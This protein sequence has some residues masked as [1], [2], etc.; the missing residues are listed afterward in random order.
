LLG[1]LISGLL[2]FPTM[3]H[4]LCLSVM[5]T[6][7]SALSCSPEFLRCFSEAGDISCRQGPAWQGAGTEPEEAAE[8]EHHVEKAARKEVAPPRSTPQ[9]RALLQAAQSAAQAVHPGAAA[10]R[11]AFMQYLSLK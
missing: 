2:G 1:A 3:D 4:V 9:G 10:V 7:P 8:A 5:C 11:K 6:L